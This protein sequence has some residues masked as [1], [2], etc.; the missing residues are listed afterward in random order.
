M[1]TASIPSRPGLA[2]YTDPRRFL[3]DPRM[4]A[5]MMAL[6]P[7]SWLTA[8]M[9]DLAELRDRIAR[10][11]A[12]DVRPRETGGIKVFSTPWTTAPLGNVTEPVVALVA[13]GAKRSVLG[14][15]V[16]DYAAGQFLVVTVDL[17][18][19][20]HITAASAREPFL[21]FSL[22]LDPPTVAQLLLESRTPRRAAPEG[23][24]LA[25]SDAT[26]GQPG[27]HRRRRARRGI[28]QRLPV[29]PRVPPRLRRPSGPGRAPTP[30][31]PP[32][33]RVRSRKTT[34]TSTY[35]PKA[36]TRI[37]LSDT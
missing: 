30:E 19:T 8:A 34:P 33:R 27:G 26:P 15:R 1:R 28:R 31:R 5:S 22:P 23:P 36:G 10:L 16:F 7:A 20:S 6:P 29:H 2:A 21:A 9:S 35:T 13:Q 4:P 17:P 18:L 24:A 11:A 37:P 12:G 14:D 32:R 3:H 25:A